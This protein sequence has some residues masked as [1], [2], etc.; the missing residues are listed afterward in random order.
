M[1]N[2]RIGAALTALE[3]REDSPHVERSTLGDKITHRYNLTYANAKTVTDALTYG[4]TDA[5]YTSAALREITIDKDGPKNSI[6]TLVYVPDEWT[7]ADPP[8]SLPPVG[9]ITKEI[10]ANPIMIPLGRLGL[11]SSLFD[12]GRMVG[13]GDLLGVD[14]KLVPQPIYIRTEILSAFTFSEANAIE[15][16]AKTFTTAQMATQ[17][18][19]AA[20]NLAWLKVGLR[21]RTVGDKFEKTER[22]QFAENGWSSDLYNTAV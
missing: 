10:D 5:V 11:S 15:N 4:T 14:G 2:V 3:E 20:T 18:L 22:W 13:K 12:E 1:A 6:V 7:S 21:V 9:T 8:E 17:G 19:S 16:V